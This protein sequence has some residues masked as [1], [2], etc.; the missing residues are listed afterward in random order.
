MI[1]SAEHLEAAYPTDAEIVDLEDYRSQRRKRLLGNLA[2]NTTGEGLRSD[3]AL[4]PVFTLLEHQSFEE[5]EPQIKIEYVTDMG[6]RAKKRYVNKSFDLRVEGNDILYDLTGKSYREMMAGGLK[7]AKIDAD[8]DSR[9]DYSKHQAEIQA[10]HIDQLLEWYQSDDKNCVMINSL[11]PEDEEL[12]ATTAELL[13]FKT[14]RMMSMNWL[15]AKTERGLVMHAFSLD[16]LT[17]EKVGVLSNQLGIEEKPAATALEQ[18]TR[19]T[20]LP[21]TDGATAVETIR[22][23]HD[24]KL[25]QEEPGNA[26]HYFGTK[27]NFEAV[28]DANSFVESRPQAYE[29]Y[30]R[31]VRGLASSL[32]TGKVCRELANLSNDLRV[33]FELDNAPGAL[34][35]AENSPLT[36]DS[37][38]AF[39]DYLRRQALPH[40][41]YEGHN[42]Q[43]TYGSSEVSV[44]YAGAAAVSSGSSYDGACPGAASAGTLAEQHANGEL[45]AAMNVH[46]RKEFSSRY[47]PNCLPKPKGNKNVKAWRQGE[48]I[49]CSDCG[50]VVDVCTGN[51][52]KQGK[53]SAIKK[54]VGIFEILFGG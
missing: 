42:L 3:D 47:C 14:D 46:G 4:A 31:A 19:L 8:N 17:L 7:A 54:V 34:L 28:M 11:C 44:A 16:G 37:S 21:F 6:E 45:A 10:G 12:P 41:I 23:Q 30:K 49:G 43:R 53:K 52:V 26:A 20:K 32:V 33:G 5:A 24:E 38:R 40:Y 15:F 36:L 18:L 48:H 39:M 25:D 27:Q 29:T 50:H 35:L 22:R 51:V 2:V 13:N 1:S 9:W